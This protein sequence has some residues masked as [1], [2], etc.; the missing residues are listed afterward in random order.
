MSEPILQ[1]L[2]VVYPDHKVEYILKSEQLSHY[3]HKYKKRKT[4]KYG[5]RSDGSSGGVDK[6][7][8]YWWIHDAICENPKW[9]D[10]SLITA[11]QAATVIK[12]ILT[13]E[14]KHYPRKRD[15]IFTYLQSYYIPVLTFAFGCKAAR[16]NGWW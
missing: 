1:Y 2:V 10:G 11:I 9:D 6:P 13:W 16:K 15:S 5:Y 14:A 3:S 4:I 7:S 12:E 8:K